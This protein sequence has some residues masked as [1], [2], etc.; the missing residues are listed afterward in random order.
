MTTKTV[1]NIGAGGANIQIP[2]WYDGWEVIRLDIDP[3]VSPDILLDARNVGSLPGRY[4]AVF[5]SHNLEHYTPSDAGVVLRGMIS[6]LKPDGFADI[7]VPDVG[8]VLEK[9][10]SNG[11]DLDTFL[12]QSA[13]GPICV[14]DVIYGYSTQIELAQHPEYM[15]H[16]NGFSRHTLSLVMKWCGFAHT[17]TTSSGYDLRCV[18]FRAMPTDEQLAAIGLVLE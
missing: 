7:F 4:D 9:A 1:L 2:P 13:A 8:T 15:T 10:G 11:W 17:L 14:R 16:K 12:Y 6:V 5:S 3:L 18:G